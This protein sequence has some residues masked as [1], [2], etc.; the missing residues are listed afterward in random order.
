VDELRTVAL[1]EDVNVSLPLTSWVTAAYHAPATSEKSNKNAPA[2]LI[3]LDKTH[4]IYPRNTE[5]EIFTVDGQQHTLGAVFILGHKTL[6]ERGV[7]PVEPVAAQAR[8]EG[9]LLEL[10]KHNWPWSMAIIPLM[11]V[12]LFELSNNHIWQTEFAFTDWGE[13]PAEYMG[14]ERTEKGFTERGWIEFGFQNYY[15]LLDCGFRLR[16][17]GGT[18]CGV[19]PV[20]LGFGRVYVHLPEGFSYEKWMAGL[21]AGRSFVTTGPMLFAEFNGQPPGHT[22]KLKEGEAR[23]M[24]ISCQAVSSTPLT[25]LEIVSAGQVVARIKPA[26]EKNAEGG[27]ESSFDQRLKLDGST[28]FAVRCYEEP[29]KG[30]LRF[31]HTAP[32]HV[33]VEG[34]PLRPRR[35]EAEYLV[36]RVQAQIDRSREVLP[37]EALEEYQRALEAY[38]RVLKNSR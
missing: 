31:A 17:T 23:E 9:A 3:E 4:V 2:E 36:Q 27:F 35:E 1:A 19:H 26:N 20:P 33:D 7:P 21:N 22:F 16:P 11:N 38:E 30:R 12:D 15:A 8:R 34:K 29:E 5:Y 32:V 25:K 13:L 18:A 24:R 6:F 28:W 14:V 37:K 10:D